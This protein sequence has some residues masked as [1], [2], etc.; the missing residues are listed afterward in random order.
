[1]A[2]G[3]RPQQQR[4][5][6]ATIFTK[7]ADLLPLANQES[8]RVEVRSIFAELDRAMESLDW[9]DKGHRSAIFVQ[10]ADDLIRWA[11]KRT[12]AV[13]AVVTKTRTDVQPRRQDDDQYPPRS[14]SRDLPCRHQPS[15]MPRR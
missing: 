7:A 2:A 5:A 15:V 4:L 12:A 8:I 6:I 14:V 9:N 11:A 3:S 13:E 1:M 10:A